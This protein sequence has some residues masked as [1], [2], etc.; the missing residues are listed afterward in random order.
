MTDYYKSQSEIEAVV[1]GFETC[2]FGKDQFPHQSH[3]TVAIWYLANSTFDQATEKMRAGLHCFLD[4]HGVD[5]QKYNETLTTFWMRVTSE[6]MKAL[7]PNLTLVEVTNLVIA[8]FVDS[9]LPYE[10][11]SP[12]R[13]N[14]DEARKG[15]VQPDLRILD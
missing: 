15:W 12:E 9:R 14:S 3:L 10:Y 2:S 1:R 11:Y 13:L 5:R 8:A 4:Y 7:G 6:R